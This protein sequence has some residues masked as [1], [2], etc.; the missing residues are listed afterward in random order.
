MLR[1][2]SLFAIPAVVLSCMALGPALALV[3]ISLRACA[4]RCCRLRC[5]SNCGAGGGG[6]I[7]ETMQWLQRAPAACSEVAQHGVDPF[8]SLFR[9]HGRC[10]GSV[11]WQGT[12]SP[13]SR[14]LLYGL[15]ASR[16][17]EQ[18]ATGKQHAA[19]DSS[20]CTVSI[21]QAS[22]YCYMVLLR[23]FQPKW[24]NVPMFPRSS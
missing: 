9:E 12:R 8:A 19:D 7:I 2:S 13:V 24:P 15:S 5:R 3:A 18:R 11:R 20:L 4:G 17:T 23:P 21:P 14:G 1:T 6:Q 10:G 22:C 16:R